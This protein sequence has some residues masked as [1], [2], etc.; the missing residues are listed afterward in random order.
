MKM[1]LKRFLFSSF[2]ELFIHHHS[3]LEFRAK[4][5]AV[6]IAADEE[7]DISELTNVKQ[8]SLEIYPGDEDRAETLRLTVKEYVEKVRTNNGLDIDSLIFAIER[9]IKEVPRYAKKIDVDY[10]ENLIEYEHHGDTI[11]YQLRVIEML[12]RLKEENLTN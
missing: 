12:G 8:I 1:S 5:I 4:L 11:T 6:V 7:Y 2:R 3:S 10:L 9:E